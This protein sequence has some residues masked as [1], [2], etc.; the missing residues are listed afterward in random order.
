MLED[1]ANLLTDSIAD[2]QEFNS[3]Y[4]PPIHITVLGTAPSLA[5]N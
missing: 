5:P 4:A 1:K 2:T 3:S